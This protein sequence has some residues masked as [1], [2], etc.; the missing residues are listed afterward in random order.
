MSGNNRYKKIFRMVV[1][2]F[3]VTTFAVS[4][5]SKLKETDPFDLEEKPIQVV[6][7]MVAVKSEGGSTEM[8]LEAP[9]LKRY[10]KRTKDEKD[11]ENKISYEK[12]PEGLKVFGYNDEGLLETKI[13]SD[14]AIHTKS[15]KEEIWSAFGNVVI[16]NFLNGEKIETDTLYWNREEHT[17]WTDCYVKLSSPEGMMQGYGMKSDEMARNAVLLNP[18]DSYGIIF[19]DS[20]NVAYIDSANFIGPLLNR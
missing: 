2:L 10:E 13:E 14:N 19:K 6:K 5:S 8:R 17:I 4:C 18:F 3:G 7:D 1:I 20:S 15:K 9:V 16:N 11:K 12:F